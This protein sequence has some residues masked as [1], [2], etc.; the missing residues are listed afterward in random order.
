MY[1]VGFKIQGVAAIEFANYGRC[2]KFVTY[3]QANCRQVFRSRG[4]CA[5]VCPISG[6]CAHWREM[7]CRN[8]KL[9][10]SG[11]QKLL[12]LRVLGFGLF[13]SGDV[14]IGVFPDYQA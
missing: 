7:L 11:V 12:Q 8:R 14:W 3:I 1:F 9:V 5:M 10:N 13:E 4:K 2:V 6:G